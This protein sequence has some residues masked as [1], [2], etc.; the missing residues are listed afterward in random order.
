MTGKYHVVSLA[1]LACSLLIAPIAARA[2]QVGI[3]DGTDM[4]LNLCTSGDTRPGSCGGN[5][6]LFDDGG[7]GQI[8]FGNVA[9]GNW[10]MNSGTA[11]GSDGFLNLPNNLSITGTDATSVGGFGANALKLQLTI[12]GLTNGVPGTYAALNLINGVNTSGAPVTVTTQAWIFNH[13]FCLLCDRLHCSDE[14]AFVY[15]QWRFAVVQRDG[16]WNGSDSRSVLPYHGPHDK[17]P[18]FGQ[19]KLPGRSF[20]KCPRAV[21]ALHASSGA[22]R[23]WRRSAEETASR[24][25][26]GPLTGAFRLPALG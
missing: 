20:A 16:N 26:A 13:R 24:L 11:S 12:V 6:V 5:S 3:F 10:N 9:I 17:R 4:Q 8:Q 15:H 2:A 21:H 25:V 18:R 22:A 14:L 7:S 19:H 1:L 23:S